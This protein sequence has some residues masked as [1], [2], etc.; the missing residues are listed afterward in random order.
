MKAGAGAL[1]L[2]GASLGVIGV[3]ELVVTGTC[4]STGLTEFGPAPTCPSGSMLDVVMVM[5]GLAAAAVGAAP[6]LGAGL[7]SV[8]I[9]AVGLGALLAGLTPRAD[10]SGTFGV[11]F[12]GAMLALAGGAGW[13]LWSHQRWLAR[14][15]R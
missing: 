5:A 3:R 1:M 12:G 8:L 7:I 4:S 11:V 15:R 13:A 2:V 14:R 9:G 10:D 6:L